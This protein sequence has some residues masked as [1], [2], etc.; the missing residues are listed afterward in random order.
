VTNYEAWCAKAH[1]GSCASCNA[2]VLVFSYPRN[3]ASYLAARNP[4][5][6]LCFICSSVAGANAA[7]YPDQHPHHAS[8]VG[9]IIGA[10]SLLLNE[11]KPPKKPRKPK[12]PKGKL[13][14][15]PMA[16]RKK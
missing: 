7:E 8:T 6:D 11:L 16:P 10:I 9:P 14:V 5:M 15:M 4:T 1:A 3:P 12:T 2:E 13:A